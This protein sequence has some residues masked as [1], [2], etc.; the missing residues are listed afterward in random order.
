MLAIPVSLAALFLTDTLIPALLSFSRSV[1]WS[2]A[3]MLSRLPSRL[4]TSL[5]LVLLAVPTLASVF[6]GTYTE[7]AAGILDT[8]SL[9]DVTII[10]IL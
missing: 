1:R 10:V 7:G 3:T 2:F 6:T 5:F 4:L 8:H 9:K